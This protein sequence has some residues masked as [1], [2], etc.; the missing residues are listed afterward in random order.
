RIVVRERHAPAT[1]LAGAFRDLFR[2]GFFRERVHLARFRHVPV[3]AEP[4][5][6][7]APGRS[8]REHRRTR[9]EVIERLLLDRIDAEPARPSVSRQDDLV[10]LPRPDETEAAL[11]FVQR[12]VAR[13]DVALDASVV[14]R[15]PVASG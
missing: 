8:E 6:E 5:A 2:S 15:V 4:A 11:P 14:E 10:L 12:A 1:E 13:A 7:V 9:E 3:L